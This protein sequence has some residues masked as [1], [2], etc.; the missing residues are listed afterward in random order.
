MTLNRV[1]FFF[2][3]SEADQVTQLNL[4]R[5]DQPSKFEPMIIQY[6]KSGTDCGVVMTMEQDPLCS[7]AKVIGGGVLKT[8][9]VWTWPLSLVYFVETYHL[10]LPNNFLD[11]MASLNWIAPPDVDVITDIPDGHIEL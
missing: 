4:L 7:P 1:G 5:R 6:L 9:G 11:R 2:E 10:E 3:D 8:D